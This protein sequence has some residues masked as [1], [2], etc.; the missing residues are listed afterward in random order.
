MAN[1]EY[2]LFSDIDLS[3]LFFESLKEDYREFITWYEEKSRK[4]SFAYT[5]Y[6]N[7]NL[8][9]F[10]YLK[11]EIGEISDIDPPLPDKKRL[12]VGTFKIEAHGTKLGERF[13]K[14]IFDVATEKSID[15]IYVTI[16]SKHTG[17][18]NLLTTF[19]F[20][21]HGKK[22]SLNGEELVLIK[23]INHLKGDILKDYPLVKVNSNKK[24]VLSIYPTY[25]TR[26]FPDSILS[27]ETYDLLSDVSHTN[28]IH[29]MYLSAMSGM[30]NF[31]KGD[32]IFI[33]RTS[34]GQGPAYYR[35]IISSLCVVE[36]VKNI[37]SFSNIEDFLGYCEPYSIFTDYELRKF[38]SERKYPYIIKMT[39]N[40]AFNK[41]V[42]NGYLVSDLNINPDYWGLFEVNN[43]EFFNILCAGEANESLIINQTTVC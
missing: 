16:F 14:K 34:D 6:E 25:H 32:L 33:Y 20:D 24:Y 27:N 12:K 10:L 36:E 4:R 15:E 38:Y 18:I 28:S 19:G 11:I 29:K 39:Y 21:L 5:L 40:I 43:E 30:K 1:I 7:G 35:S 22:I 2:K 13:V 31:K 41:K 42:T 37:H 8:L 26:L 9:A 17:L 3:D 23:R